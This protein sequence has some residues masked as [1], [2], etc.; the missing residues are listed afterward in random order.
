MAFEW[1]KSPVV[2]YSVLAII[3]ATVL[4]FIKCG[5]DTPEQSQARIYGITLQEAVGFGAA[6]EAS[7]QLGEGGGGVVLVLPGDGSDKLDSMM[8]EPYKRGFEEGIKTRSAIRLLGIYTN[9]NRPDLGILSE[10][11][12]KF[13]Q[14]TLLVLFTGV[15]VVEDQGAVSIW[16]QGQ[17]PKVIAFYQGNTVKLVYHAVSQRVVNAGIIWK[18][19]APFPTAPP[20]GKHQEI[21]DRHYQILR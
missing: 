2:L 7:N 15:P 12:T 6:M 11:R 17:P 3:L 4:S 20:E 5:S 8:A 18:P 13:P 1:K 19:N 10:V 16:Q 21:F 9:Y 14:A